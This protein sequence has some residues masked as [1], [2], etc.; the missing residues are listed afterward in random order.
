MYGTENKQRAIPGDLSD[1]QKLYQLNFTQR[2][3]EV[4]TQLH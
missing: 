2:K 4:I 3:S 1:I